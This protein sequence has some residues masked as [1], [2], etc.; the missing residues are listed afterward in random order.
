[1]KCTLHWFQVHILLQ[2][3]WFI[4]LYVCIFYNS[5]SSTNTVLQLC[6]CTNNMTNCMLKVKIVTVQ[7]LLHMLYTQ[8]LNCWI[9]WMHKLKGL[10]SM[11]CFLYNRYILLTTPIFSCKYS[12]NYLQLIYS[13]YI[14]H[15]VI[16]HNIKHMQKRMFWKIRICSLMFNT[17]NRYKL[18]FYVELYY[19][20]C[21][22]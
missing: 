4:L 1:M 6:D 5:T 7:Y 19:G 16:L 14:N 13:G 9:Q 22:N 3:I 21:I 18:E 17:S 12:W 10:F 15:E 20:I 11:W 8:G 2:F